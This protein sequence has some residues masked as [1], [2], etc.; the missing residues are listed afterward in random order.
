MVVTAVALSPPVWLMQSTNP[1]PSAV[2][3][4]A[5]VE[6]PTF[7]LKVV[8][9]WTGGAARNTIGIRI[10]MK[11]NLAFHDLLIIMS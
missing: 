2:A 10:P 9:A 6:S 3:Q 5:G 8:A 11:N 1:T 4:S 7:T